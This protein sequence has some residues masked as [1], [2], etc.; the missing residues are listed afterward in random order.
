M[1]TVGIQKHDDGSEASTC[2]FIGECTLE[3][4]ETPMMFGNPRADQKAF[5]NR[6]RCITDRSGEVIEKSWPEEIVVTESRK[7]NFRIKSILSQN[8]GGMC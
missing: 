1:R 7:N 4:G 3:V 6:N 8:W 5:Y 2:T